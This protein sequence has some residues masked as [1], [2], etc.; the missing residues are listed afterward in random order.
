MGPNVS[1]GITGVTFDSAG[2]QL[3]GVAYLAQ[4]SEPKP[5][6]IVLHG[7][8]GL[9]HNGDLAADLRDQGWNALIFH[10]RGCWGSQGPYCLATV[11]ADVRSAADYLSAAPFPG[12]DPARLA[13]IGHSMGGVAAIEAAATDD[14]LRAVVTIGAPARLS[15]FGRLDDSELE[16]EFTRFLA[17]TPAEFRRQLAGRASRPGPADLISAISPRPV[18][19]VHGGAD[20]WV[21]PAAGH[22]LYARA[23][24]PKEYAEIDGADH[25][26]SWHRPELRRLV[27]D[28]LATTEL[29]RRALARRVR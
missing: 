25:S 14:R 8:P 16:R 3:V 23:A 20:E 15:D 6:A 10:Y 9:D 22:E 29:A 19:I 17:V 13:V 1:Y 2:H 18:L 7:C 11:A 12:I 5:T 21:P 4:G 24:E 28:W 27:T 26:I